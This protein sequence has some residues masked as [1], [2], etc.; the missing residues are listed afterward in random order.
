[1]AWI[2]GVDGCKAGWIAAILDLEADTPPILRVVT[3]FAE[4]LAGSPALIAVDMPIG[5]PDL[6]DGSGRG[7]EQLVRPLLGERQSSVF[8]IPARAAVE[9]LD[10]GEAC[11]RALATS[12]PPRKVSQ[13]GF[14]LFPRIRE[15]DA[16]LRTEP[17]Q[18]ERV[19][20]VHPELA[21]ATM[22]GAPLTHPKK[23]KGTVN[24]AGM[25]ERQALL[26]A[27]GLP[28]ETV[29][30]Q[31]PRGAAA[32]DAL[33]AL[34]ALV[35]AQHIL[36]GRGR[37]FPDPP[38]RD[39]HGLPIAIWTYR[40][41]LNPAHDLAL[42]DTPMTDRPVPRPMIE[43]AAQR[44]AGHARVTPVMRLGSGA[45][46]SDADISLKLECLQHAGSF[47]TRGAF[48]NL[49]SLDLPAAGVAAASGG[50]HG[51]AVAYAARARG[52]KA[53]IFVPE[54]SP[55]AKIEAIRRFGA[56]VVIGG[57]QY[58]DAQAACDRFVAE[59][60]A[61]KIHPFAASETI[62]GQGTLGREWQGQEPDLDTVLVAVGGGGLIS[63]IAAWFA[64]TKVK[65]VGVEPEG[66]RALQAA[67][68]AKGPT[69]VT[70][71][72]VAAD[73]L[74]ARNVGPLVYEVCKDTVDHVVLV[75]DSAI[76]QAQVTLWRDFRV[77]VEPGG[78]AALGALLSGT[79][80]PAAGERL[81]VLVCG[82]NIDLTKLATL[83]G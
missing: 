6:I 26:V 82:A 46:G 66:S 62:A 73:S 76:T 57:A 50:N 61:L 69:D 42:Q 51:A 10:Y 27:A 16:L 67:L 45:F 39:S 75:P 71:A 64:G 63:G 37:P 78:A 34:A 24:P 4:L 47:K 1:M 68:Q 81:G 18:R 48:N 54:I 31:P 60:G 58:D 65:V 56:E 20:E 83:V 49:L 33:D 36:A 3:G 19:Y 59:T 25:A 7:P 21:F 74:G 70:V 11:Q 29:R 72:S 79:Y 13:Q 28:P 52:V 30:A 17:P 35:V 44:I 77:A 41:D 43:A 5:L 2:A 8:S 53:T 9:A 38:R 32:D 55:A 14:H 80:K 12:Q 15:I 23:I 22:R 40:P